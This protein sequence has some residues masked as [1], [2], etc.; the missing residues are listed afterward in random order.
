M[1]VHHVRMVR[2]IVWET[3]Y[4]IVESITLLGGEPFLC[5]HCL[6]VLG[7]YGKWIMSS[8]LLLSNLFLKLTYFSNTLLYLH[9]LVKLKYISYLSYFP[10]TPHLW[11]HL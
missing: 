6:L 5:L 1:V 11:M 3:G 2:L 8:F 9:V 4:S 7:T 10:L